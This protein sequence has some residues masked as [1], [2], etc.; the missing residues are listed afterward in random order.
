MLFSYVPLSRFYLSLT[1]AALVTSAC[2]TSPSRNLAAEEHELEEQAAP[3]Q[4]DY[5]ALRASYPTG[6]F[7]PLWLV[8]SAR[9]E[10]Q[11][12]SGIPQG[13]KSYRLSSLSPLALDP[14]AFTSLGPRPLNDTEFGFGRVSGRVNVIAVDPVDNTVAYLGSDGGGVWKTTNCCSSTTTWQ[15]TTDVASVVNAAIGDI[16]IDPN[17]HNT[18]YAGTGDLRYG[19]FSFGST[20]LLK[21]T[22]AGASWAVLGESEFGPLYG[23]SANGFPQYQAI[24][25][26]VV[27]PNDSNKVVVG[28]K[29]GLFFSYDAGTSW[30]G[31][32]YTNAFAAGPN[33]QRQDI[34]GLIAVD[35]GASTTLY[36]A[37]G[38]RGTPTPVQPNLDK[39]G[40]N[41]VYQAAMPSSG[42]PAVA[43]WTLRNT[44]WPAGTGDGMPSTTRGR[45]ELAVAP[46]NN[47]VLYAMVADV[48]TRGVNSVLKSSDGG[49]TWA[50]TAT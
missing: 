38:T 31:P 47:Q 17:N 10:K 42:C 22:D 36:A 20:G 1:A 4:G 28:T 50:Q 23:P 48:T 5:W 43:D 32:C 41:G 45:I 21:S 35:L 30:S 34:T 6:D 19:S 26:V 15:L 13:D 18:V 8:E 11:I 40:A 24:G 27:D 33:A 3:P 12:R 44:G 49:A 9:A 37:I 16:H 14:A 29:T 46:S 2:Q 39:N 7:Q 25:K